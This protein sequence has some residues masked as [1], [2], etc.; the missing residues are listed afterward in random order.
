MGRISE[1]LDGIDLGDQR[2]NR[3]S[4][5]V[6]EALAAHPEDSVNASFDRWGDTL[7]AYRL[8]DNKA[9]TPEAILEPHYQATQARMADHPVVLVLQDTTELDFSKHPPAD[10][11]CLNKAE[12]FGFYLHTHLAVTPEGLPLGLLGSETFSRTVESLGRT[13]ERR[14]LPTEEKE[15]FRWLAGYRR[16][17]ELGRLLP[18]TQVVS[19]ADREA[20]MYDI[21]VEAQQ[22]DAGADFVIRAK[23]DRRTTDRVPPAEHD[24]RNAVYRKFREELRD[25]PVRLTKTIDLPQTPKR[26]A[27]QTKLEIRAQSVSLK[28]P[29]NRRELANVDCQV[30]YVRE[31]DPP[32]DGTDIE[33]WLITSLP[34]ETVADIERVVA[35]YQ[36]RWVIEVYFRVL[37]TGC[38]VEEMQLETA[39]RVTTCLAFYQIIAWRVL[40]L[41]HLHRESPELSCEVVFTPSQWQ[42]VW[43]LTTQQPLP[44]TVPTLAE[45]IPLLASLGGYNNRPGEPPPGPQPI[46]IGV[47]RAHDYAQAWITFGP[48]TK[49]YV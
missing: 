17:A 3:R 47:R 49:T 42:S 13:L 4:R 24:S 28:H 2:L 48:P 41:T 27:R 19:V 26:A 7:G 31:I 14:G 15:S 32:G 9:A 21:F 18:E 37:K 44:P 43:R 30:V 33:W 36:V 22:E 23:E 38:R 16:A 45:F 12:R 40:S 6:I 46:W 20:D 34:V 25:S 35:Y 39:A 8:F 5:Q 11:G 10:A 1:E 29:K